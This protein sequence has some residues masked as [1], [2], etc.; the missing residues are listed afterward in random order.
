MNKCALTLQ[1]YIDKHFQ[2]TKT[3]FAK[4]QGVK[5]PQVTQWINK[6]TVVVDGKLYSYRRTLKR[7]PKE[8]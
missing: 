6:D 5:P 4:L 1:Q 3:L 8:L 2:G 7:M